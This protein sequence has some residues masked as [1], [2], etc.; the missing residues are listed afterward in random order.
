MIY[1]LS[2]RPQLTSPSV[3]RRYAFSSAASITVQIM[4]RTSSLGKTP[5]KVGHLAFGFSLV[6]S[7]RDDISVYTTLGLSAESCLNRYLRNNK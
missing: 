3:A 7:R 1:P 5:N 6:L 2:L 4:P